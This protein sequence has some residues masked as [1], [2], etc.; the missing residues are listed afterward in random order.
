MLIMK[1]K[2]YYGNINVTKSIVEFVEAEVDEETGIVTESD[3]PLLEGEA[4]E[5]GFADY[6]DDDTK[7]RAMSFCMQRGEFELTFS[8]CLRNPLCLKLKGAHRHRGLLIFSDPNKHLE[9]NAILLGYASQSVAME[10]RSLTNVEQFRRDFYK[11]LYDHTG[12]DVR[13][14][15][16]NDGIVVDNNPGE[17]T[18][19]SYL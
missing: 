8:N 5:I 11:L 19:P 3:T 18:M 4:R 17:V 13:L 7:I 9:A 1:L 12:D 14:V 15:V 6:T 2:R 16:S 10:R